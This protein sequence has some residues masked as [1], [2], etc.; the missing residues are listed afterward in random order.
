MGP[1]VETAKVLEMMSTVGMMSVVGTRE[2]LEMT[3][4]AGIVKATGM[5]RCGG[6]G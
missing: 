4:M 6:N 5:D 1:A 3:R 2:E